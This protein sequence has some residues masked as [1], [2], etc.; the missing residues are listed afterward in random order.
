MATINHPVT[1]PLSFKVGTL[2][3]EVDGSADTDTLTPQVH[4]IRFSPATQSGSWIGI[5][6]NVVADN[7]IATWNVTLGMIQDVAATGMLRWLLA[8]EGKK[9]DFVA[10]L[11]DGVTV[12]FTATISPAEIGGAVAPGYLTSTVTLAMDGKPVFS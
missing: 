12:A 10:G 2:T 11:V 6:G 5:G 7:S 3:A 9:A 1:D 4:E 8:N